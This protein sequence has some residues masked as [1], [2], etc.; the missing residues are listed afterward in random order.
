MIRLVQ[1]VRREWNILLL[2]VLVITAPLRQGCYA[3]RH[4][5]GVMLAVSKAFIRDPYLSGLTQF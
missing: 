1:L 2:S 5:R 4:Y 3:G